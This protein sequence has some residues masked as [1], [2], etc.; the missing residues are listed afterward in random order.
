M[1]VSR[2]RKRGWRG[3][4]GRAVLTVFAAMAAAVLCVAGAVSVSAAPRTAG[5]VLA[6]GDNQFGELGDARAS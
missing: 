5:T 4:Y 3:F 1:L 6:W 2:W